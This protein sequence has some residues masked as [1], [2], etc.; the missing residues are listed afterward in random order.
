[1]QPKATDNHDD[2]QSRVRREDFGAGAKETH[3]AWLREGDRGRRDDEHLRCIQSRHAVTEHDRSTR[4]GE[5]AARDEPQTHAVPRLVALGA[6][7]L[8]GVEHA[9]HALVKVAQKLAVCKDLI[10][11]RGR[12]HVH[13]AV[14]AAFHVHAEDKRPHDHPAGELEEGKPRVKVGAVDHLDHQPPPLVHRRGCS[15]HCRED[16]ET[17]VC[18]VACKGARVGPEA[19][20]GDRRYDQDP[21]QVLHAVKM[22]AQREGGDDHR[23]G[24]GTLNEHHL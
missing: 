18:G 2:D 10:V 17:T 19:T 12:R 1:M 22:C 3:G 15:E 5:E 4:H 7:V 21:A 24:D 20:R 6:I 8:R 14:H 16:K 9:P 11:I 13:C 23:A